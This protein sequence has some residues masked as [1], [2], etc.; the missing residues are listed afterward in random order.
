MLGEWGM[1]VFYS[2]SHDSINR[3]FWAASWQKQQSGCAPSEDSDQPGHPPSLI[4]L[5]GAQ[6]DLS[7]RWAHSHIVGFYHEAAFRLILCGVVVFNTRRFVLESYLA[8]CF[9]FFFFF[10][11]LSVRYRYIYHCEHRS[12]GLYASRAFICLSFVCYF[13][14]F[15]LPLYDG[16]WL[17]PLWMWHS[18]DFSFYFYQLCRISVVFPKDS[19]NRLLLMFQ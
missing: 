8:S 14:S 5:A 18:L 3:I 13:L 7:L 1:L 4:R 6:A 11:F 15:P 16:G 10:F 9:F 12:S 2:A 19:I 17:R